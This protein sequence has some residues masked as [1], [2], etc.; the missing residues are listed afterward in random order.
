MTVLDAPQQRSVATRTLDQRLG[1]LHEMLYRRGGIRPTNAAVEELTKL[2]LLQLKKAR[3]P[4]WVTPS[5]LSIGDVL[6]PGHIRGRDDVT[7]VKAAFQ[8]VVRLEEFAARLPCGGS[9]PVWPLDEPLRISRADV[10]AEALE[11]LDVGALL[12]DPQPAEYDLL[13]MAFDAFLRGRYDHAGGLGTY[14]TPHSVATTLAQL[15][16]ADVDLLSEDALAGP[17]AGDPCCGTGRF[18]VAVLHELARQVEDSRI[19]GADL[20]VLQDRL[21]RFKRTGLFGADQSSSSVAKARVNL[22]LFGADRPNVF[23]VTD[24][25]TDPHVDALRGKL[26]IILTNPP[27]GDRKYD[28]PEGTSRTRS[29]LTGLNGR[30]QIDPA[31]AFVVRCLDLLAPDGRL[32]IVLPDGLV[33]GAVLRDAL[34]RNGRHRLREVSIE[35]NISLPTATFAPAGTVAKTSALVLR[36]SS[37]CRSTVFLARAAHVGYLK[38]AGNT[39]PDPD[40]DDLPAIALAGVQAWRRPEPAH[41]EEV[42]YLSED[43]LATLVPRAGLQTADPARVDPAANAARI[44]LRRRGGIELRDVLRPIK[45]GSSKAKNGMPFVSVLH[46]DQLGSVAWDQATNYHPTTPGRVA[47]PGELL[48]SLLNPRHLRT[49]VV[50]EEWEAVMCSSE[51][52]LFKALGDPYEALVLLHHPD[53]HAQLL[54]LGRGTSSSRRRIDAVDLLDLYVPS[55]DGERLGILAAELRAAFDSLRQGSLAAAKVYCGVAGGTPSSSSEPT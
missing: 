9:Q 41:A 39:V 30:G 3:D 50:P 43:P 1:E 54:P 38:Q 16:L 12:V 17:T 44:R 22:L 24:S 45:R 37:A 4:A 52:G 33:D 26:K 21:A 23:T 20:S 55:I 5:G 25:V 47:Y 36:K 31:L 2:L 19:A 10:L 34:L 32:G 13:G 42:V 46:I 6:S 40:G 11:I 15:A 51:F 49:T 18:L 27:F 14:L 48:F 8:A 7:E 28:S 35:A 53:V 29:V